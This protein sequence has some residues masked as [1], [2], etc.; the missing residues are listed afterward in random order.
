MHPLFSQPIF[1][2][3]TSMLPSHLIPGSCSD[4]SNSP[5][6]N[7][8]THFSSSPPLL[9]H[10]GET[11]NKFHQFSSTLP[12]LLIRTALNKI[13][14]FIVTS[15]CTG[16]HKH[17]ITP[18]ITWEGEKWNT[19]AHHTFYKYNMQQTYPYG[20]FLLCKFLENKIIIVVFSHD[21][22]RRQDV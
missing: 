14:K 20:S 16:H 11:C 10:N 12:L 15:H 22:H 2:T 21:I 13:L 8:C 3:S 19:H 7:Y 4:S 1:L 5:P 18:H 6:L 17:W 9:Y